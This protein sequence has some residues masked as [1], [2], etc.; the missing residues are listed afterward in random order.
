MERSLNSF[1]ATLLTSSFLALVHIGQA[2]SR[3]DDKKSAGINSVRTDLHGDL[4]PPGTLARI[5]TIRF[6]HANTILSIAYSPDG[7][8][9]AVS[10]HNGIHLWE[11][12]TGKQLLFFPVEAFYAMAFSPDGDVLVGQTDT[13]KSKLYLWDLKS[14]REKGPLPAP[15]LGSFSCFAF[16]PDDKSIAL[17]K[18]N[19]IVLSER[20]TGKELKKLEGINGRTDQL[21]FSKDI[22]FLTIK[23]H[24][25]EENARIDPNFQR[26]AKLLEPKRR[27][28][29][30]VW[31]LATGAKVS[32]LEFPHKEI[33][34]GSREHEGMALMPDGLLL[35]DFTGDRSDGQ[36]SVRFLDI[37]TGKEVRSFSLPKGT[38]SMGFSRDSKYMVLAGEK[39]LHLWDCVI[40]KE[41]WKLVTETFLRLEF[42][43]DGKTLAGGVVGYMSSPIRMW[44]VATGR[45]IC[46]FP[47]HQYPSRLI[48]LSPDGRTVTTWEY[49]DHGSC[50]LRYWEAATGKELLPIPERLHKFQSVA[51]LTGDGNTLASHGDSGEL[52]LW[53]V[54]SGKNLRDLP[55]NDKDTACAFSPDG[56]LLVS[57]FVDIGLDLTA[58]M[59][60][61]EVA[62]GKRLATFDEKDSLSFTLAFS[63]DGKLLASGGTNDT[64]CIWDVAARK[65]LVTLKAQVTPFH[66]EFSPDGKILASADLVS[67]E[68]KLWEVSTGK[69]LPSISND[70]TKKK[71]ETGIHALAFSPDG[72]TIATSDIEG[73][74]YLWDFRSKMLRQECKGHFDRVT[75]FAFSSDGKILASGGYDG[76]ILVWDL[77]KLR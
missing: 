3:S 39:T 71:H 21:I 76:T 1:L 20:G 47:E 59:E 65:K 58:K 6:R 35:G 60:F 16:S 23:T 12:A 38:R 17:A 14:N 28:V 64:I 72:R 24:L 18:A 44:D 29:V 52:R 40:G 19:A 66:F 22:K 13:P 8:S 27:D 68:I 7:K 11:I 41:I 26:R 56:K 75:H 4:L 50:P 31:D 30:T 70:Q 74:I 2:E 63:A 48:A 53:D 10:T 69:E 62:T 34:L 77:S 33:E 15:F 5:G 45:Q 32:S 9:L 57:R 37:R 36:A 61:W 46:I 43:P 25:V 42:S 55:H 51:A 54:P 73:G 67:H 49:R